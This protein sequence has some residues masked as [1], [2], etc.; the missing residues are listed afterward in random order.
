MKM[1]SL[2]AS[3]A[4]CA[5]AVSAMAVTASAKVLNPASGDDK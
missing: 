4:A 1:K 5:I 2:L 3:I